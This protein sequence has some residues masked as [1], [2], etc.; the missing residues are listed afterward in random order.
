MLFAG[1]AATR[2]QHQEGLQATSAA[3]AAPHSPASSLTS[4]LRHGWRPHAGRSGGPRAAAAAGARAGAQ[5]NSDSNS[6]SSNEAGRCDEVV[7]A[8]SPAALP[9]PLPL[10]PVSALPEPAPPPPLDL[11]LAAARHFVNLTNGI[12]ALPMLQQL[13]L[14]YSFVRIQS[15]ACEQQNLE[16]LMTE[17]DANLLLHLA[18]GHTCIVYDCGSRRRDGTPR[19]LWYGL[20]FVRYCLTQLWK[21]PPCP[22]LLRGRNVARTFDGHI[23]GFKQ[24]TVKR[25]KYYAKYLPPAAAPDAAEA[26]TASTAAGTAASTAA[27]GLRLYGAF[28]ATDHDDDV[29][30]YVSLLHAVELQPPR[31]GAG[32]GAGAGGEGAGRAGGAGRSGR[33]GRAGRAGSVEQPAA[34]ALGASS[35]GSSSGGGGGGSGGSSA[36]QGLRGLDGE[37]VL[38]A[39]G[40]SLFRRGLSPAEWAAAAAAAEGGGDGDGGGEGGGEGGGDGNSPELRGG[41]DGALL[42]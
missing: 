33:A 34:V 42:L 36:T 1:A 13:G 37:A 35:S 11:D 41:G 39:H 20:E 29:P 16:L 30:Y 27:A 4:G 10:P 6:G 23:R 31:A 9:L 15:T 26:G 7:A 19:A 22:A 3:G 14:H 24:S 40:Y 2:V 8:C 21:L 28:R 5:N 18:L 17:L 12:E 38:A 32:A 25:I